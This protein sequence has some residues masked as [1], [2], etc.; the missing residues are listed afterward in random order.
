MTD[1]AWMSAMEHP[2]EVPSAA[3]GPLARWQCQ[4]MEIELVR[5][6]PAALRPADRLRVLIPGMGAA[7]HATLCTERRMAYLTDGHI[8]VLAPGAAHSIRC[9]HHADAVVI[10]LDPRALDVQACGDACGAG[11]A[12]PDAFLSAMGRMLATRMESRWHPATAF[13]GSLARVITW[14]VRELFRQ[15]PR[16]ARARGLPAHKLRM[17]ERIVRARLSD[18]LQVSE[19]SDAVGMSAGHFSR[20]FKRATGYSPC[21]YVTLQRVQRAKELLRNSERTLAEIATMVGLATPRHLAVAFH[22]LS[23]PSPGMFRCGPY[24]TRVGFRSVPASRPCAEAPRA[25]ART[26]SP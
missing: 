21:M 2:G 9:E 18:P 6:I 19:I 24:T 15:P 10:A 7:L 25:R 1:D 14:R 16:S 17:V 8:L 5:R 20:A 11:F 3:A 23:E 22:R 12:G 4:I 26:S 13:L